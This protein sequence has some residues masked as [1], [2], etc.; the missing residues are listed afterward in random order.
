[1]FYV[2]DL[3]PLQEAEFGQ[4]CVNKNIACQPSLSVEHE[5]LTPVF[6]TI[7]HG[8]KC[9]GFLFPFAENSSIFEV[10]ILRPSNP[11]DTKHKCFHSLQ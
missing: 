9:N 5:H 8:V 6:F 11:V 4:S 3:N 2:P 10:R 1:M 7:Y